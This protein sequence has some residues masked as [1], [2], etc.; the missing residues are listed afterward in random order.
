MLPR[1]DY[2]AGVRVTRNVRNDGTYPG[3]ATGALL[4]RRGAT[5]Y[6]RDVGTFLQ[7]QLIYT[8]AF[9]D[10][11]VAGEDDGRVIGCREEEL[12]GID[13]PWTPTR[14]ESRDRVLAAT[15]LVAGGELRAELGS[16]GE[17]LKVFRDAP[18]GPRYRV[19]FPGWVLDVPESALA[20]T[21]EATPAA[22]DEL[23]EDAHEHQA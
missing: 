4:V 22:R 3:L 8:V 23:S 16:R 14:F 20:P 11:G 21:D 12:I 18:G 13:E 5:G 2:G 19:H 15:A 1:F 10:S 7:D 9:L 6:V 17:V